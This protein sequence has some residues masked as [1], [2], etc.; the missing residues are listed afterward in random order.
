MID[1]NDDLEEMEMSCDHPACT[2][3][4]VFNGNFGLCVQ[5]AKE[6]GWRV[7]KQDDDRM[8]FCHE[9]A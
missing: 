9:H 3:T 5:N 1:F 7:Q 4:E 8:R 6:D 2:R